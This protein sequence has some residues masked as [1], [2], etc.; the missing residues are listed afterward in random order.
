MRV[1]N[2]QRLWLV[3]WAG[4]DAAGNS[5]T[6]SW[7]PTK[8]ILDHDM[9]AKFLRD[10][11]EGALRVIE[12]DAR[13]LD[14]LVQRTVAHAAMNDC[15]SKA[16]AGYTVSRGPHSGAILARCSLQLDL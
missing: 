1:V 7:E 12:V 14:T 10:R 3:A 13:P 15:T 2:G 16:S 5:W 9:M 11:R 4:K 8:N 6:P